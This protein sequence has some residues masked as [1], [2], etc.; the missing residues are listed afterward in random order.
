MGPAHHHQLTLW[1]TTC[2]HCL[3]VVGCQWVASTRWVDVMSI[4]EWTPVAELRSP[5]LHC[6]SSALSLIPCAC[7]LGGYGAVLCP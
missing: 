4:I 1:V 7:D 5:T 6:S 3:Y 2:C